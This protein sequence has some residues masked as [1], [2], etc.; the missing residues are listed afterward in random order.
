M[1]IGWV[2]EDDARGWPGLLDRSDR[3]ERLLKRLVLVTECD[4]SK[5]EELKLGRPHL[6]Q[7][8]DTLL[9]FIVR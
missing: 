5:K 6:R 3:L 7:C 4:E 2:G 8:Q 1:G 9:A